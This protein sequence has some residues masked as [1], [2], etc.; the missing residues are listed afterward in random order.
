[1]G[2]ASLC[3]LSWLGCG[4]G[5]PS[6][7]GGL[8][9][10]Y[11]LEEAPPFAPTTPLPEGVVLQVTAEDESELPLFL[12][13]DDRHLYW[14]S[15]SGAASRAAIGSLADEKPERLGTDQRLPRSLVLSNA[16]VFWS[17]LESD[18]EGALLRVAKVGGP[19]TEIATGLITGLTIDDGR[20]YWTQ[21]LSLN[22]DVARSARF[23]GTDVRTLGTAPVISAVAAGAGNVYW[24]AEGIY[25]SPATGGDAALVTHPHGFLRGLSTTNDAVV[26]LDEDNRV[27]SFHAI[28]GDK[29]NLADDVVDFRLGPAHIYALSAGDVRG[30][31]RV[32][33]IGGSVEPLVDVSAWNVFGLTAD[34]GAVYW[35]ETSSECLEMVWD[36]KF[37]NCVEYAHTRTINRVAK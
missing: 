8:D 13:A 20:I 12:A 32:P 3:A 17:V 34:N 27:R 37:E 9:P 36:H 22:Q 19:V 7:N 16:H 6:S 5:D 2:L 30:I 4:E 10:V 31:V 1:M 21:R 25:S 33:L 26:W 18:D 24:A 11:A 28:S 15:E 14:V 23:N 35:M 29:R